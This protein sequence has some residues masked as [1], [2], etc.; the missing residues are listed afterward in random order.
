[1][2]FFHISAGFKQLKFEITH[3]ISPRIISKKPKLENPK[4]K[5]KILTLCLWPEISNVSSYQPLCLRILPPQGANTVESPSKH[6]EQLT[7]T[8]QQRNPAREIGEMNFSEEKIHHH[9]Q[10]D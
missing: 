9:R 5:K 7:T 4:V 1:M 10:N 3:Q 2:E 6:C 8:Y